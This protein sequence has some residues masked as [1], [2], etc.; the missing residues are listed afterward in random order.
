MTG[1]VQYKLPNLL[2]LVLVLSNQIFLGS[3]FRRLVLDCP[4]KASGIPK[5]WD[6]RWPTATSSMSTSIRAW[7]GWSNTNCR[8]RCICSWCQAI[9]SSWEADFGP[10]GLHWASR[11]SN[12][13][14]HRWNGTGP[15]SKVSSVENQGGM[16]CLL[17]ESQADWEFA[18]SSNPI[19]ACLVVWHRFVPKRHN[20][21][22]SSRVVFLSQKASFMHVPTFAFLDFPML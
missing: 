9:K 1:M 4:Q 5:A 11:L 17:D 8:T 2:Y 20:R 16:R 19:G 12:S 21:H 7:L 3:R 10:N 13:S 22:K 18:D 6:I 14:F 15:S